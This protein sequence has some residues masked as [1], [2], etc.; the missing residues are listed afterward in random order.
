MSAKVTFNVRNHSLQSDVWRNVEIKLGDVLDICMKVK[1][2]EI[3][4]ISSGVRLFK[5]GEL[6]CL[7]IEGKYV[8][9]M[10]SSL[11]QVRKEGIFYVTGRSIMITEEEEQN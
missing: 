8:G 6:W 2:N 5:F 1:K 10:P 3:H 9:D 7:D 4:L 11:A